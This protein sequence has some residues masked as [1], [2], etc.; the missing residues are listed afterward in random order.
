MG[1]GYTSLLQAAVGIQF[2]EKKTNLKQRKLTSSVRAWVR[3][4]RG[5]GGGLVLALIVIEP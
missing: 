1:I 5:G 4:C 3:A 2:F